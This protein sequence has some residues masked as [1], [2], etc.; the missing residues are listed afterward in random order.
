[1]NLITIVKE[2][3]AQISRRKNSKEL[4]YFLDEVKLTDAERFFTAVYSSICASI[5][6][7][8]INEDFI[9]EQL[10]AYSCPEIYIA[11]L[12]KDCV[13]DIGCKI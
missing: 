10:E 1:M 13:N 3:N 9:I 7:N 5:C 4:Y 6:A 8:W 12:I 11:D 2:L